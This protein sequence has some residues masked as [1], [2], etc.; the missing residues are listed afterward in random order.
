MCVWISSIQG[1]GVLLLPTSSCI[2]I[3]PTQKYINLCFRRSLQQLRY[4]CKRS[5]E[6]TVHQGCVYAWRIDA[7]ISDSW[8]LPGKWLKI[9]FNCQE[10]LGWECKNWACQ[11][12]VGWSSECGEGGWAH[13]CRLLFKK[14]H[15]IHLY[16]YDT[17]LFF[18]SFLEFLPLS[19]R[20]LSAKR[21]W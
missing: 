20:K 17:N 1:C 13:K 15:L 3:A 11:Q 7:Q 9:N 12:F 8:A 16:Q 14:N 21:L 2:D 19:R 18:F 4:F 5:V 10:S 6:F